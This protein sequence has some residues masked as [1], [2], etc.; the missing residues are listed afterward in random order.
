MAMFSIGQRINIEVGRKKIQS[1]VCGWKKGGYILIELPFESAE[2]AELKTGAEVVARLSINGEP[3]GFITSLA[4]FLYGQRMA[5]LSYPE[6]IVR[7]IE[8]TSEWIPV[9]T[10]V[11]ILKIFGDNEL[12][13]WRAALMELNLEG[14]RIES[15]RHATI[16]EKL[17]LT[18]TLVTGEIID[19]AQASVTAVAK[20]RSGCLIEAAFTHLTDEN[21]QSLENFIDMISTRSGSRL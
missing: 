5:A 8:K 16:E 14:V 2:A 12:D 6:T 4:Q 11:D 1:R 19:N 21:R 18:F 3:Y 9:S 10:P 20:S 7:N 15:R 13:E 17:F